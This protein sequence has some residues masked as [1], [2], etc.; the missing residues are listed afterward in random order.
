[1]PLSGGGTLLPLLLHGTLGERATLWAALEAMPLAP[2]CLLRIVHPTSRIHAGHAAT[3]AR[4]GA[5]SPAA[6]WLE[7]TRPRAATP[8]AACALPLPA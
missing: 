6:K 8:R 7:R 4:L 3:C 1:M 5:A 2:C